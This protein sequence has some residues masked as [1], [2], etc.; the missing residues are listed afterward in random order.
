[1]IDE[2]ITAAERLHLDRVWSDVES[3]G[4]LHLR[5]TKRE[6]GAA[7]FHAVSSN[8]KLGPVDLVDVGG[9]RPRPVPRRPFVSSTYASIEAT[10]PD[11][12]AWKR[13]GCFADAGFTKMAGALMDAAARGRDGFAVIQEEARLIRLAFRGLRVPQDGARGGRDLRL[14]VGGDVDSARGAAILGAAARPMSEPDA[15][16]LPDYPTP[17]ASSYGSSQNGING[18]G[19]EFERPSAGTPSL[20]TMARKGM[21]PTPR[22]TRSYRDSRHGKDYEGLHSVAK[23]WPTPTASDAVK[24]GSTLGLRGGGDSLTTVVKNW[25]TP[26]ASM[27]ANRTNKITPSVEDGK[28]GKHLSAQAVTFGRPDLET[29]TDGKH[30]MAL[31]PLFVEAMMGLRS[32]WTDVASWATA[33]SPSKPSEPFARSTRG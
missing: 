26:V 22:V 18:K 8:R 23:N 33:S 10:C 12:C 28:H 17:S 16:S 31:S 19:G 14:H 13:K 24:G 7:R 2:H 32:G 29:V 11:S 1:M 27:R 25:A 3:H 6:T 15:S 30:G 21:F 9:D 5:L 4:R 20:E